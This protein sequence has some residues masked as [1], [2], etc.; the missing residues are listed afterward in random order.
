MRWIILCLLFPTMLHASRSVGLLGLD[1]Q[2]PMDEAL[3]PLEQFIK[4]N[5]LPAK[6]TDLLPAMQVTGLLADMKHFNPLEKGEGDSVFQKLA[7]ALRQRGGDY[8]APLVTALEP[9]KSSFGAA[10]LLGVLT[11]F[12]PDLVLTLEPSAVDFAKLSPQRQAAVLRAMKLV[13]PN[14]EAQVRQQPSLKPYL[15]GLR[16]AAQAQLD[17]FLAQS[18]LGTSHT[19]WEDKTVDTCVELLAFDVGMAAQVLQHAATLIE[20][21]QKEG[22]W[23]GRSYV[24]G[25]NVASALLESVCKKASSLQALALC[26]RLCSPAQQK[27]FLYPSPTDATAL[28]GFFLQAQGLA[29]PRGATQALLTEIKQ[30]MGKEKPETL[31]FVFHAFGAHLS[32]WHEAIVRDEAAKLASGNGPLKQVALELAAGLGLRKKGPLSLAHVRSRI[33]DLK[34]NPLLSVQFAA[35]LCDSIGTLEAGDMRLCMDAVLPLLEHEWPASGAIWEKLLPAFNRCPKDDLWNTQAARFRQAWLHRARF[36]KLGN[37]PAWQRFNVNSA[38]ALHLLETFC[39]SGHEGDLVTFADN[40][41]IA[42]RSLSSARLILARYRCA[43]ELKQVMAYASGVAGTMDDTSGIA[44]RNDD[45]A[46]FD[47]INAAISDPAMRTLTRMQVAQVRDSRWQPPTIQRDQRLASEAK[48]LLAEGTVLKPVALKHVQ[49]VMMES[50]DAARVLAPGLLKATPMESLW[51]SALPANG[52][53]FQRAQM[54]RRPLTLAL[55]ALANGD[56]QPWQRSLVWLKN[57]LVISSDSQGLLKDLSYRVAAVTMMHLRDHGP[58]DVWIKRALDDVIELKPASAPVSLVEEV[59]LVRLGHDCLTNPTLSREGNGDA[60]GSS[61]LLYALTQTA[62][63][64]E[65][66]GVELLLRALRIPLASQVLSR[67]DDLSYQGR[68]AVAWTDAA[69]RERT[70][71]LLEANPGHPAMLLSILNAWASEKDR[72]PLLTSVR[73]LK[74]KLDPIRDAKAL[75]YIASVEREAG[76][77]NATK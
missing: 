24:N 34:I 66:G 51:Q 45:L 37:L 22:S 77:K 76:R 75:L 62:L 67:A 18:D 43:N 1:R 55:A 65:T 58:M 73:N 57:Q 15:A 56:E 38:T 54:L 74:P 10:L 26:A 9:K 53:A 71:E 17:A 19:A 70:V 23:K 49:D 52:A 44:F 27:T 64:K 7:D 40:Y 35:L 31:L 32:R 5:T 25:F 46:I 20:S 42:Y 8:S 41:R 69:L 39:R 68:M 11:P 6:S 61:W 33:V 3:L 2:I 47:W 59:F 14:V 60:L 16:L 12:A 29:D 63:V 28:R 48:R 30:V 13:W 50:L 72:A 21:A 36:Q 4:K